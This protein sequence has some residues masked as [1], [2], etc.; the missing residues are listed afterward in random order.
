MREHHDVVVIGGGQAGLAM[1][2]V[3]QQQGR[4]HVV[5]E[6]RRVGER[7]RTERWDSLHFQFPNWTLQLPGY[8]YAG[9]DPDGFAHYSE[10]LRLI[11]HY[12]GSAGVTV[13]ENTEVRAVAEHGAGDGF[14]VFL[15]DGSIHARR[16]VIATGPFQLPLVPRLAVDVSP[17][18][19]Q[20]DP[21]HYRSPD[22]LPAGAVLVVGSGASGCQIADELLHAGR[23]VYVSVSRHRR[24]PRRFRGRDIYWWLEE[25]GRFA[26]TID[27][28][29]SRQYPPS[30]VVTGVNGGYDVNVRQLASEGAK[31]IG[32]VGGAS[33]RNLGV[34]ANANQVLDEADRAYTDFLS[35]ARQ[36]IGNGIEDDLVDEEPLE[37]IYRPTVEEVDSLNLAREDINTIVWATGYAYDF[38]WVKIPLFDERGR[39]IQQRGVTPVTGLYF[40]GLHWMHTF[41][42]GLFSGVGADATFLADHMARTPAR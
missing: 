28:F 37:T 41:K 5:L 9:N 15:A 8:A 39:P 40:L 36:F 17:T 31:V 14:D 2:N 16:V 4:E 32:R 35:A 3:L 20:L 27:S 33:G 21:T 6:R 29:P 22:A 18:V 30:T 1:S 34:L 7:W 12:A 24:A 11:E 26:Q 23:R 10:V 42:S 38:G 19:L 25:L 13:R